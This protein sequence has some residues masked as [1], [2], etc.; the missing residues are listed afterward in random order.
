MLD[1]KICIEG[2]FSIVLHSLLVDG[3]Y[4]F[5]TQHDSIHL[6]KSPL[7]MFPEKLI[8]NDLLKVKAAIQDYLNEDIN[9]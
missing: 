1:D 5:L 4:K 9:M 8:D 6:A 7:D 2:M 3:Q